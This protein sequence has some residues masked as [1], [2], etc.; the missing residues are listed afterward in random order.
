[1]TKGADFTRGL[2]D[3]LD[4]LAFGKEKGGVRQKGV[5]GYTL[6]VDFGKQRIDY[7]DKIAREDDTTANFSARENIVVFDCVHRLLEK[8]YKPEDLTLEKK[9]KLGRTGK[10][11]KA[12]IVVSR[13]G[14]GGKTLMIIECKTP[15]GEF[16]KEQ[17][18]MRRDGGQLFSYFQQDKAAS[19]LA[20]YT[21]AVEMG[22][23]VAQTKIVLTSDSPQDKR[24]QMENDSE[25]LTYEKAGT[26]GESLEV[27]KKRAKRQFVDHGIFDDDVEAYNPGF[28]PLKIGDLKEFKESDRGKLHG[29]FMEI[30]RH[31]NISD[32]SNAF[33]RFISLVLAKMVDEAK[34]ADAVAD[35]Q[36]KRGIDDADS[37]YERLQ[38]LY[39]EAMQHY[40]KE[41]IV[42]HTLD[43]IRHLIRCFPRQSAK[44]E[45]YRVYRELKLYANNE[46][47]F[48]E[49]YNE[50]LYKENALV[51]EEVVSLF[52]GYR[53]KY[54]KK[55]QF[56]GDFFELMLEDG[57]KQTEGQFFTPTPVARFIVSALPLERVIGEKLRGKTREKLPY[58]T[59][60]AC[61]SG[62]FLTESIAALQDILAHS[63]TGKHKALDGH[64]DN[65]LW[66]RE[67][68][69][70]M[71]RD[72]RL[73]RTSQVACFMHG[74]GD[75]NI[76]FGDGLE[77]HSHRALPEGK[78][79]I[80]V[81]NPPY[82]ISDFK[83][84]LRVHPKEFELWDALSDN[85]DNIEVF[86]IERMA[87]LLAVGGCAGIVLP[88]TILT[89]KGEYAAGRE[90]LMRYF[91][92]KAVVQL[93]EKAFSATGSK[94]IV[95]FLRR[96]GW[97]FA[98]NCRDIAETM[99]VDGDKRKFDFV[100]SH[101]LYR[102]FLLTRDV[103]ASDKEIAAAKG[104]LSLL[105]QS[106]LYGDYRMQF[107]N[108]TE[109]RNM[110]KSGVYKQAT[111]RE[112]EV[113]EQRAFADYALRGECEK[114]YWFLLTHRAEEQN[115][116]EK[117]A[118]G[119]AQRWLPQSLY[120]VK[121]D[122]NITQQRRLLGYEFKGRRG[123]EGLH[124]TGGGLLCDAAAQAADPHKINYYVRRGLQDDYP[125]PSAA[126]AEHC[127][128]V[129][130]RDL[131]VF[132]R[133]DFI[134]DINVNATSR[135]ASA[136]SRW[137]L[138]RL[139][140]CCDFQNGLWTG[141]NPPFSTVRVLRNTEFLPSGYLDH[142][143]ARKIQVEQKALQT[144]GLKPGDILLEKSGGSPTQPI[145]RV[146]LFDS[147][148]SGYSFGNFIA[149]IR[150]KGEELDSR[151]VWNYLQHFYAQGGTKALEKGIRIM[152]LDLDGYKAVKIP[153]PPLKTQ[154]KIVLECGKIDRKFGKDAAVAQERK[155]TV[156]KKYL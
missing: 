151:Y 130:L 142:T 15:G 45:L 111:S 33:N 103:R 86:F 119:F 140:D 67:F 14:D 64:R 28:K 25:P 113:H 84:H 50:K 128:L 145:G 93:G 47:A 8:G 78:F 131:L 98:R 112:K 35:F 83:K 27:W 127:A 13:S 42:N 94:T 141:K 95:L 154:R 106:P 38:A 72:Y 26:V 44:D 68:V 20:L 85:S 30:L 60:F 137:E 48:K 65:T 101:A 87:Q 51:L 82:A 5:G 133:T 63:K 124:A 52:Q 99:I 91:E 36:F 7:G 155:A 81:A 105:E 90:L 146:A 19:V 22:E 12:D 1:M 122:G 118:G 92:I 71:E 61:G 150:P 10:S 123:N 108:S 153:L 2:H 107:A 70:G 17:D 34:P 21:C 115:A 100:D 73:A 75:A 147:R 54:E 144:R 139:G 126:L 125:A 138:S 16:E 55:S 58:I 116:E 66:A 40:L 6:A 4:A 31:N 74:D 121:N 132:D 120:I 41:T 3:L 23:S 49:I 77:K 88:A 11:G 143:K 149:R 110:K 156:L 114:F 56:L 59:D 129:R 57:Y 134:G 43:R 69:W 148:K 29:A 32:R 135:I 117:K 37:L 46:F 89:N 18:N 80:L 152:N 76:I 97:Q 96:R 9:W 39:A 136:E 79:D 104:H 53:F 109:C 62:H 102:D 24:L